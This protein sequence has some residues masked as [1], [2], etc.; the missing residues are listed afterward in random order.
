MSLE[1]CPKEK[2]A[3]LRFR[4]DVLQ[5]CEKDLDFRAMVLKKCQEDNVFFIDTFCWTFDPR[6]V[7]PEIPFILYPKQEDFIRRL[8]DLYNRSLAGEKV[9]LVVEKPR[10]VGAT[11][12]LM[13]WILHKYL[14]SNFTARLGSRKEDYVDKAGE[15][16]TL[17]YKLDYMLE[18][19]PMWLKGEHTRSYMMMANRANDNQISGESANPN[20]SRAGRK[21]CLVFDELAFWGWARSS[22]E[23][24]GETTNFRIALSTPPEDGKDSFF[25]KLA[26]GQAGKV[27]KFE[28]DWK[29]VPTRDENWLK[30]ARETKSEEEFNREVMKS[31]EGTKIGRIYAVSLAFAEIRRVE[32]DP[33]LPLFVAWD[34]GLD[35]TPIIWLQKNMKTGKVYVIDTYYNSNLDIDFYVPFVTG[36]ITSG[37]FTYDDY[38]MEI[39]NRHR[40][41]RRDMTHFGD[42]DV[43]KRSYHVHNSAGEPL[44]TAAILK[45]HGIIVQSKPWA[46]REQIELIEKTRL[47][48]RRLVIDDR[49]EYFISA[50]RSAKFPDRE[51]SQSTSENNKPI[52]DWCVVGETKV[53]TLNGWKRIKD[54]GVGEY[55]WGYSSEKHRLEIG[56]VLRSGKTREQTDVMEIGLDNGKNIQ[57]TPNHEFMLRDER[58]VR[59]DKLR[60]QDSLMPFY[61]CCNKVR[62]VKMISEK[63]DVYD[64][65]VENIHTFA[66]EGVIVHNSS[67]FRTALEYFADN[68]PLS[69]GRGVI[70]TLDRKLRELKAKQYN[71][72]TTRK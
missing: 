71:L 56:R 69:E 1:L 54:I 29:D 40:E 31:Y 28:F 33:N 52:H 68:E 32:Y 44:T 65:T 53:R 46:G 5:Q 45:Q 19:I 11:F 51:G 9:N 4:L 57:C 58:F 27:E 8:D 6:L 63:M 39:I 35:Q 21:S 67:H 64:L 16:D 36:V 12:T 49:Q 47:L 22:W 7:D 10:A 25:Y 24:S 41:W 23:S 62:Y 50:I 59:A 30:Q 18:R 14:F 48:F 15:P 72:K 55:V 60:P 43:K 2:E 34:F 42:P 17:Y 3:N 66:A 37:V 70:D 38:E 26:T 20:F 61:E 13:A